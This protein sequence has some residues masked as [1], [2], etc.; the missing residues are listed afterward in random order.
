MIIDP[1]PSALFLLNSNNIVHPDIPILDYCN[2]IVL[3]EK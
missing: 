3:D 2:C 1:G